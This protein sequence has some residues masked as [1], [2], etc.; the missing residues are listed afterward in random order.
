[1]RRRGPKPV[2]TG[3]RIEVALSCTVCG[4]RNYRTTRARRDGGRP[5]MLTKFCKTC[6]LHTAHIEAR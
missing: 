4:A 1:V 5:L 6:N 2:G 3:G